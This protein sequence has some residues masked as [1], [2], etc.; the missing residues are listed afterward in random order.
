MAYFKDKLQG[1][2]LSVILFVLTLSGRVAHVAYEKPSVFSGGMSGITCLKICFLWKMNWQY[3]IFFN[4]SK[5][6]SITYRKLDCNCLFGY[7]VIIF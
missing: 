6:D 5:I 7:M 1:D 3:S 2:N 4:E